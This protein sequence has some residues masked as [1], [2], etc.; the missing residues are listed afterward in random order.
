MVVRNPSV[1]AA[2]ERG[3]PGAVTGETKE[4]KGNPAPGGTRHSRG[5]GR[6][7]KV[8]GQ[9]VPALEGSGSDSTEASSVLVPG[10]GRAPRAG[11]GK[12][13]DALPRPGHVHRQRAQVPRGPAGPED[14][15]PEPQVHITAGACP[16]PFSLLI[17]KTFCAPESCLETHT[18]CHP[19]AHPWTS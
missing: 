5:S 9:Q 2:G 19:K 15:A 6:N 3:A 10:T 11:G 13:G 8:K 7:P 12:N 14:R 1:Y 18:Q 4:D 16:E 17:P